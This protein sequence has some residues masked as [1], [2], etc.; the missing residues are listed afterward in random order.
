MTDHRVNDLS[1]GHLGEISYDIDEAKW[2]FTTDPS[3]GRQ[4]E[5]L[6]PFKQ[7]IPPSVQD[8]R[9]TPE[10]GQTNS[11]QVSSQLKQLIKTRPEIFP[12]SDIISINA[13]FALS[14]QSD[15][16]STT[17]TLLA[18]GFARDDGSKRL[19]RV[20]IVAMPCG[21]VGHVLR[22]IKPRSEKHGWGRGT[23][24]RISIMNPE[25]G[26]IG[27]W[28][29][30]E[31]T[32]HQIVFC[33]EEHGFGTW[34]AVR[35]STAVTI[36]HP[37]YSEVPIPFS[38]PKGFLGS[39]PPSRVKPN[40]I[41]TLKPE[42]TG[43]ISH[44]DVSFNPWYTRQ[45]IVVDQ[46]GCWSIWNI[47]GQNGAF[48]LTPGK[49]A[50]LSNIPMAN[51]RNPA[52]PDGWHKILWAG[53]ISTVVVCNR[54]QLAT[55]DLKSGQTGLQCPGIV[56]ANTSNWILDVKRSPMNLS[57]IFV[58]T[59]SQVFWIEIKPSGDKEDGYSPFGATILLSYRHFRG[60]NDKSLRLTVLENGDESIVFVSS[61]QNHLINT[62]FFRLS[63]GSTKPFAFQSSVPLS[64]NS[65]NK[66]ASSSLS[67]C[68]I[69]ALFSRVSSV[70]PSGLGVKYAQADVKFYQFWLLG[71]DLGLSTTLCAMINAYPLDN[72]QKSRVLAP[73]SKN[74]HQYVSSRRIKKDSF[75]VSDD[76]IEEGNFGHFRL[77]GGKGARVEKG[78][79]TQNDDVRFRVSSRTVFKHI[80]MAGTSTSSPG[81]QTADASTAETL[82]ELLQNISDVIQEGK[83]QDSL[84][85]TTLFEISPIKSFKEE[86]DRAATMMNDF[87]ESIWE[88]QEPDNT[89]ELVLSNVLSSPPMLFWNAGSNNL[90][91]PDVL[92]IYDHLV[93]IWITG[94]PIKV[95]GPARFAKF[96][97]IQQ[98]AMDLYFSSLC[99]SLRN[100]SSKIT[101]VEPEEQMSVSDSIK[102]VDGTVSQP[103]SAASIHIRPFPTTIQDPQSSLLTPT[104]TPSVHSYGSTVSALDQQ[105]DPAITRL[106]QYAV[107]IKS[108]PD[109]GVQKSALLTH[110]PASPGIDP[111][112][113]SWEAAK[114]ASEKDE[115]RQAENRHR[116]NE[117]RRRRKAEKFLNREQT[118]VA[119]AASQSSFAQFGSQPDVPHQ[120]FSSQTVDDLPMT[121]PTGGAFGSRALQ[122]KK[123]KPKKRR[124]A[125]FR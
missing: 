113:Y 116:R 18:I 16:I 39:F 54:T 73:T 43:S 1:Y 60:T 101:V 15:S 48:R 109:F 118:Q 44:V 69:P 46:L 41:A 76:Y 21:E 10:E 104:Q 9:E 59:T 77:R 65:Y 117:S 19:R 70:E 120:G 106:R 53:N 115:K 123:K 55:F 30:P 25:D 87:L 71:S 66:F 119:E 110:W 67:L 35:Q 103:D 111:A 80:F 37:K 89:S 8:I 98:I 28:A 33:E 81:V 52:D 27:Y 78:I 82:H 4:F 100:K 75:I 2:I 121:Q 92:T 12:G 97:F 14:T 64:T 122:A 38:A 88:D 74:S 34:F 58:L 17:G 32:I 5:Q 125:G 45:F 63:R 20:N 42:R 105:E 72:P 86:L 47:E 124:T 107:S 29:G 26:D 7:T 95:S 31:G 22:L 6:Q 62:Y 56:A 23:G 11:Q 57:H 112:N 94:L 99:L 68:V 96:N 83:E 13:R 90:N 85:V 3:H 93:D 51:Q 91:A 114:K 50:K 79:N 84:P 36:F 24:M 102:K 49:S 108:P 40:P 61:K